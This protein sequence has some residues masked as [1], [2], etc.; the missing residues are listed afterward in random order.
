MLYADDLVII[1]EMFESLMTKIA[2]WKNGLKSKGLKMNMEKTK[3]IILHRD[4][5]I[6]QTSL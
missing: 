6:L 4:L 3:V 2:V 5:H 1:V